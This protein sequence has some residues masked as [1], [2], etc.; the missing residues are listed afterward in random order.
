M[1]IQL[2]NVRLIH[3][4]SPL[5]N[6]LV[7]I[8]VSDGVVT[9]IEKKGKAGK[10]AK[11]EIFQD[12]LLI[13][14]ANDV[15]VSL[16]WVDVLADYC[17]PGYEHKET[18]ASGIATAA[19]AGFTDVFVAP[20]TK[21]ATA[22]KSSVQFI[23]EQANSAAIRL[24]PL[25]AVTQNIEGTSLA[26]MMDMR[27]AGAIAFSDGWKPVQNAGLLAK[28]LE[29]VKAFK[30]CIIQIP[31]DQSLSS[32]GLMN[33]SDVSTS[34][35]MPG[36]P[37]LAETLIVHRDLELLKYTDSKLHIT[38]ISTAESVDMVRKAKANGL[39]VTCSVSPYHLI[40]TEEILRKYDA[41][42]K[43]NPPLRSE[44]DRVAL[45]EGVK[46]GTIDCIASHHRPQDW[47]AKVKEFEYALEGIA[48]QESMFPALW[49]HLHQ[50]LPVETLVATLSTNP[51]RIFNIENQIS[52]GN[53]AC[54]T[55]FTT[56]ETT[57]KQ[58]IKSKA[59][60]NPCKGM[61]LKG[62]VLGIINKHKIVLNGR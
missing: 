9:E 37:Y 11:S 31:V 21:P 53:E 15:C 42:Y 20:N 14:S 1:L 4:T 32:G 35:G 54:L 47:D 56:S 52:V 17:E 19:A 60:N 51:N 27:S 8:T 43:V 55:L 48:M 34:M 40:F 45:A 25:G 61:E 36:I 23:K 12:G 58:S 10:T 18:L 3:Q 50:N 49:H 44:T 22:N 33:E 26:E 39:N 29:Y 2:K 28:A 57:N 13:E 24:H 62:K 41:T 16:G 46:D 30:G 38:G 7:N 6:H 59:F 5:H